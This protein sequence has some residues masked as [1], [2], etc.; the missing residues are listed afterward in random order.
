MKQLSAFGIGTSIYYPHPVPRLNY[1]KKRYGYEK[2]N[3]LM[4]KNLV[5]KVYVYQ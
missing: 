3:L 2:I 1:Y 4:Q 5:I